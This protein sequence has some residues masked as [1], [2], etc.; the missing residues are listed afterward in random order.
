VGRP[1]LWIAITEMPRMVCSA[2]ILAERWRDTP[3]P[4]GRSAWPGPRWNTAIGSATLSIVAGVSPPTLPA[5]LTVAENVV[6]NADRDRGAD[7][8]LLPGHPADSDVARLPDNGVVTL[9]DG[10][11]PSIRATF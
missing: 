7:G 6:R 9:S 4:G 10:S 8:H 11:S 2:A 1:V 5:W 3:A